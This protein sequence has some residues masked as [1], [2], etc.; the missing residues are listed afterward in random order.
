MAQEKNFENRVKSFLKN[1]GCY[2]VKYWGGG[3][4]TK[5]G[6]PDLLICC[7]GSFV[8]VELKAKSG[9]PSE[10]QLYNL[11]KIND[12]G[13]FA[14]LLYPQDFENFKKFIYHLKNNNLSK[15]QTIYCF[16]TEKASIIH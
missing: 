1:E 12:A 9:K 11:R 5:S 2:L 6:I 10:L 14:I 4:F 13:G 3:N 15:A 16:L 8:A 7:N